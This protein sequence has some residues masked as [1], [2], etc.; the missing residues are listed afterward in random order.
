[1]G[2]L[3]AARPRVVELT[4]VKQAPGLRKK[5]E[6]TSDMT[7]IYHESQLRKLVFRL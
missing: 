4:G 7:G 6:R 3:A 2:L 1:V 5:E